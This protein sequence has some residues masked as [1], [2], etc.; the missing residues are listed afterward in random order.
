MGGTL[1]PESPSQL[2]TLN[3]AQPADFG[4][5]TMTSHLTSQAPPMRGSGDTGYRPSKLGST[6]DMALRDWLI[7]QLALYSTINL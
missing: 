1:L 4:V 6:D 3:C 7:S 2:M 5:Q